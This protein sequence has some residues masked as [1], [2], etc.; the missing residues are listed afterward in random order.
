MISL[1]QAGKCDSKVLQM[2]RIGKK[3]KLEE[4]LENLFTWKIAESTLEIA[5]KGP[6]PETNDLVNQYL[7][8]KAVLQSSRYA[9]DRLPILRDTYW[10][11]NVLSALKGR[12]FRQQL[13]MN[14]PTF[15]A[16]KE[17]LSGK[18]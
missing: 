8:Y 11:E 5:V 14:L 10:F 18:N 12:R 4:D 15:Q 3:R 13:R 1:V 2:P 17:V 6:K 9:S 7:L 16:L